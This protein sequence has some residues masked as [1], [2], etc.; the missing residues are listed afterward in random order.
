MA[1]N[2]TF[3][4]MQD[5][6]EGLIKDEL[7]RLI[8]MF[9][10]LLLI[11][12][13]GIPGNGLVCYIYKTKYRMS[14]SRW[15][16][17][18]LALTD[19]VLCV[20]NIPLEFAISLYQYNFT[21]DVLCKTYMFLNT[22]SM[23]TLGF[24]FLII[25]LDRYRKVCQPLRWQINLKKAK[26]LSAAAVC[27]GC[28]ISLPLIWIYGIYKSELE[29]YDVFVSE[30]SFK[31][32]S[33]DSSFA[34]YYLM[35]GMVLFTGE[36]III[37]TMHCLIRKEI[38]IHLYEKNVH[39]QVGPTLTTA[40][41]DVRSTSCLPNAATNSAKKTVS[42]QQPKTDT[43]SEVPA[44]SETKYSTPNTDG[45]LSDDADEQTTA[46]YIEDRETNEF[47]M[48][49]LPTKPPEQKRTKSKRRTRT[50]KATFSMFLISLIFVLSYL[51]VLLLLLLRS[52]DEE[53]E[54]SL[55]HAGRT[56]Y[57]FFLR[58]YVLNCSINPFIYGLSDSRFRGNCKDVL[59]RMKVYLKCKR[60]LIMDISG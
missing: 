4:Q 21:N 56:A 43:E 41:S 28:V 44:T 18:F 25:S 45:S 53:F 60:T 20:I 37:C 29:K 16:V 11:S 7:I 48:T 52:V 23:Q 47:E 34:F 6:V 50:R 46:T 57:K 59:Y 32:S 54:P 8:P 3:T 5:I 19:I 15:F 49:S 12:V 39:K 38:I 51:P 42:K 30:C 58:L 10:Y 26:I 22:W 40:Q 17:F 13:I 24:T 9:I 55:T 2:V 1:V 35:V 33:R 14:G 31:S 27:V 36:L